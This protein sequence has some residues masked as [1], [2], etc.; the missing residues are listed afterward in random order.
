MERIGSLDPGD[1]YRKSNKNKKDIKKNAS[2]PSVFESIVESETLTASA[3]QGIDSFDED[4]DLEDLLDDVHQQGEKLVNNP[5]VGSVEAYKKSVRNFI[6]Y[7]LKQAVKVENIEGAKF[8][9]FKPSNK[10]KRYTLISVIDDKLDKLAA[11]ILMNQ[12][13]Q[14]DLLAK[15]EEIN[16][17]LVDLT[18]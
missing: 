17:L 1:R 9:R 7:V 14:L 11:G 12:G 6:H 13:K 4:S 15:V 5:S 10:Q 2:A 18:S 16:G 8:N 3:V